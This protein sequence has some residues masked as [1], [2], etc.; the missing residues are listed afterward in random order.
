MGQRQV[1]SPKLTMLSTLGDYAMRFAKALVWFW[2]HHI[3][4][5]SK[6]SSEDGDLKETEIYKRPNKT[7]QNEGQYIGINQSIPR[8]HLISH[9]FFRQAFLPETKLKSLK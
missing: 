7:L 5:S 2:K 8:H 1:L 4:T 9:R 6:L 3:S